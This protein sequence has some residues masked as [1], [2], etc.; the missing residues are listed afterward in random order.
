MLLLLCPGLW[1]A[2][3]VLDTLLTPAR[4][5]AQGSPKEEACQPAFVATTSLPAEL[6]AYQGIPSLLPSSP[7][8]CVLQAGDFPTGIPLQTGQQQ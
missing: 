7:L 8:F 1:L 4:P 5:L 6:R 2:W 3:L